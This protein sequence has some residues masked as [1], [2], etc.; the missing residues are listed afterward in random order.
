MPPRGVQPQMAQAAAS[1]HAE[2]SGAAALRDALPAGGAA[3]AALRTGG[4]DVEA[5]LRYSLRDYPLREALTEVLGLPRELEALHRAL[6]HFSPDAAS[7]AD[8]MRRKTA[9]LLPLTDRQ[10]AAEFVA[11]YDALVLEQLAPQLDRAL[12]RASSSARVVHYAA[13]PT[14][15][16]Q[17]PSAL[18]QIRPHCDGIYGLQP[19]ALNYWLPLT[20]V[21]E[22]CTLHVESAPGRGDFHALLPRVGECVR[23]N[24]R[25]CLHY[26]TPNGTGRTRVSLDFRCVVGEHF[27][28]RSRLA[29]R[30]YYSEARADAGGPYVKV[31]G[32]RVSELHGL[33]HTGKA[34]VVA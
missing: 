32:G 8:V 11:L 15:R 6:P 19:G 22:G 24:G 27:E 1:L 20:E 3:E 34:V 14:L 29:R 13:M 30:G 5:T 31:S 17:Q 2:I 9:L 4:L 16:V 23:F 18:R 28:Q 10:R 33:P 21:E 7:H 26:T 25:S 12:G